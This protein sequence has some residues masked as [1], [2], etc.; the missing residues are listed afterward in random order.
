MTEVTSYV[1]AIGHRLVEAIPLQLRHPEFRYAFQWS[2]Y[3]RSMRSRCPVDPRYLNRGMIAAAACEAR[4]AG[5]VAH[6]LSH[7]ALRHGTGTSHKATKYELGA[8][9]GAVVGS[10]IGGPAGSVVS[11]G[12]Q[13][14]LGTAFLRFSREDEKQSGFARFGTSWPR[15]GYDPRASGQHVQDNRD[16]RRLGRTPVA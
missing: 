14:G 13:F 9:L 10:I 12:T 5:V 3:A 4:E 6:E 8:L 1:A 2:T 15:A 11:Q 16:G 7:V